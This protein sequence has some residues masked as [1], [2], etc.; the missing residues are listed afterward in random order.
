VALLRKISI[1][2]YRSTCHEKDKGER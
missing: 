1:A 2:A